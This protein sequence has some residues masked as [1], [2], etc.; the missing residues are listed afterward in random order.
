VQLA[1]IKPALKAPGTTRLTLKC[2][3]RRLSNFAFNL[4]LRRYNTARIVSVEGVVL[5][6]RQTGAL[7]GSIEDLAAEMQKALEAGKE[8]ITSGEAWPYTL[9]TF[10]G[11][12]KWLSTRLEF[13]TSS[14]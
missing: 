4:S 10:P 9:R 6:E 14:K 1:L 5:A 11:Y 12:L 3:E 2:D 8:P 13:E 7:F